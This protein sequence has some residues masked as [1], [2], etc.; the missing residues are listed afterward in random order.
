MQPASHSRVF[1]IDSHD[2]GVNAWSFARV[3]TPR[4]L[5]GLIDGYSVYSERTGTFDTRRELPHAEGVMIVNLAEPAFITGGD[6]HEITL[7]A[8][9]A[10][11]AGAHLRPALSRSTGA[12]SGIHI[13]LSLSS[14][15]RLIGVPM[16]ELSD[17]VV[18]LDALGVPGLAK[19]LRSL[20]D[21][22]PLDRQIAFLDSALA[23]RLQQTA[24]LDRRQAHALSLLRHRP[25]LDIAGIATD[26]GWSR[27]HLAER[28]HDAVGIGPRS[29]R[30]LLRFQRLTGLL[31]A[32]PAPDWAGLACDAGYCDQSHLIREFREFAGMTPTEYLARSLDNGGGVVEG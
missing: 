20:A 14:L 3:A 18:P 30:R 17:R 2:D 15:R 10:F 26:I 21:G 4:H 27:K 22:M 1:R 5:N 32:E 9:E 13:N 19:T 8:G 24:A 28:V 6:G 25:D 7:A 29:F 31:D 16:T 23:D 12:Q 11:V